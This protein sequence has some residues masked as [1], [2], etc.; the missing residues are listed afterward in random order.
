MEYRMARAKRRFRG[1]RDLQDALLGVWAVAGSLL[2]FEDA[3]L[4]T[5]QLTGLACLAAAA[6]LM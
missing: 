2:E 6:L 5:K 1:T 3:L 4:W